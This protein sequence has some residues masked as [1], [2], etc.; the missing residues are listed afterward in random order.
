MKRL[1][2]QNR[3]ILVIIVLSLIVG[4]LTAASFNL[5]SFTPRNQQI[6]LKAP[7]AVT[8]APIATVHKPIKII[9]SGSVENANTVPVKTEF[10][11]ILSELY[12]TE[13][14]SVKSGQPLFTV[15][16]SATPSGGSQGTTKQT[17]GSSQQ[18]QANY[19]NALKEFVRYQKL[20]EIGGIAR[21]QL[22]NAAARLQEAQANLSNN[23]NVSSGNGNAETFTGPVTVKAPIDGIVTA[24]SVTPGKTVQAE[25]QLMSLGS[26]QE[27]EVVIPIEQQDLYLIHLGDQATIERS[28]QAIAGQVSAIYPEIKENQVS[29]F[30]AHIKLSDTSS[31]LLA[32]GM[33]VSVRINTG[34]S[35]VVPA[36]PT[37]SIFQDNQDRN[38]IY[39]AVDGKAVLQQ[40]TLGEA[41]GEFTELTSILPQEAMVITSNIQDIKHGDSVTAIK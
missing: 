12:V 11:G 19:D 38:F 4:L 20:Y 34:Q 36:V 6:G 15:E 40:I 41:I 14:Q 22:D 3:I 24:L 33:P 29:A 7:I 35:A 2:R 30:R 21:R 9:R 26:G 28:S 16:A 17:M 27:I 1:S 10:P 8:I 31:G 32:L 18:L 25:Q 37:A 23:Q 13:G 39:I 5:F